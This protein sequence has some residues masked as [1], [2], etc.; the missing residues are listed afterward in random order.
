MLGRI[1]MEAERSRIV[2]S[3]E[4]GREG[5]GSCDILIPS[6]RT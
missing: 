4:M 5:E 1:R 6:E 2:D 3:L